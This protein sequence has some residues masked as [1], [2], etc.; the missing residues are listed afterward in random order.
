MGVLVVGSTHMDFYITASRLPSPGET[1]RGDAFFVRPGGKGAN[2][3]VGCARL[4]ARTYL[5]SAVGGDQLGSAALEA[6]RSA[7]VVTDYVYVDASTHTGTAFIVL[8]R[9][10]GENMIVV[11]PGADESVR[12]EHVDKAFA[13]LS[14]EVRVVLAQLE[15]PLDTVSRALL[16]GRERGA[17][18]IL[19]PA[20]ARS[21]GEDLLR[22]VDVLTPNRVEAS[23]ISGVVV[24]DVER[25]FEA[26]ELILEKGP[27]AV[28]ITMGS[29]G[30]AVV[31]RGLRVHVPAYR[32]RVVD[33]VGAGDAFN[34]AL[35]VALLEGKGLVEAV[36]FANAAA[37]IKTT[38]VGAQSVPSRGEVEEFVRRYGAPG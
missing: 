36:R 7:G 37:A 22:Y 32:V 38:R 11:A 10:T 29:E 8:S 24:R 17:L 30:A 16:R 25:A 1:I 33:S 20:P 34:S 6:L 15:I 3:A 4:G 27:E 35:A 2:Q 26:G 13:E 5:V 14:S 28:V 12:P 23:Q 31:A 19:N 21:V 9:D 18:T